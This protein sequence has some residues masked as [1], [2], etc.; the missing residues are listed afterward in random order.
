MWLQMWPTRAF[1]LVPNLKVVMLPQFPQ[2]GPL[3]ETD[4]RKP[5]VILAYT[6]GHI[7]REYFICVPDLPHCLV[8]WPQGPESYLFH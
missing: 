7:P 5:T 8:L 4:C 2:G 3:A 1:N 6:F